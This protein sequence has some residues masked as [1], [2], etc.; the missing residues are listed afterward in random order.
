MNLGKPQKT[1]YLEPL[2]VTKPIRIENEPTPEPVKVPSRR[3]A[4]TAV[5][6]FG[7]GEVWEPF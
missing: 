1:H 4:P 7:R 3:E 5:R 2:K 6:L